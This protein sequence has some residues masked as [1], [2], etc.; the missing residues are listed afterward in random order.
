MDGI[1]KNIGSYFAAWHF[2]PWWIFAGIGFVIVVLW[3][4][5]SFFNKF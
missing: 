5:N 4:L 1:V 2:E 3:F